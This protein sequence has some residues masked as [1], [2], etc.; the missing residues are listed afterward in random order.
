MSGQARIGFYG[1]TFN[2]IHKGHIAVAR[3]ARRS[4]KLTRVV[5]IPSA[6]PP[7][8]SGMDVASA[9]HRLAMTRLAASSES[10]LVVSDIEH[11]RKGPSFTADTVK[12]LK[13]ENPGADLFFIIGSDSVPNLHTWKRIGELKGN[14]TFAVASR[15]ARSFDADLANNKAGAKLVRIQIDEPSDISSTRVRSQASSGQGLKDLPDAVANYI[16]E[17][18]L[19]GVPAD[20]VRSESL[21]SRV[22]A[23]QPVFESALDDLACLIGWWYR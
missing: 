5:L 23:N 22:V 2:P 17:H 16:R 21:Y 18:G 10:S 14:I 13:A 1:G 9:K 12:A 3:A 6:Q 8:K 19:Y 11:R 4:L 20:A 7:H 15:G